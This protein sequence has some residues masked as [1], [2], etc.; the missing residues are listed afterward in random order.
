MRRAGSR[1]PDHDEGPLDRDRLDFWIPLDEFG[2]RQ[3]VAQQANH[4]LPQR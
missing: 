3:P 1:H 2:Q 4:A